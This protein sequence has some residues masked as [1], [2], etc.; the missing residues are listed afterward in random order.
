MSSK[1]LTEIFSVLEQRAKALGVEV[2]LLVERA[3]VFSLSVQKSEIEKFESSSSHCAGLR[4]LMD[5]YPG[6]AWTEDLSSEALDSAFDQ[7]IENAR[8]TAQANDASLKVEL[9][10]V[11]QAGTGGHEL[12]LF[13]DGLSKVSI[14][15]KLERARTLEKAARD[16]D[17]RV[18]AVPYNGYTES[19]SEVLLWSSRG[20]HRSQRR[21]SISGNS[22]CLV[23]NDDETRMGGESFFT[24]DAQKTP[25]REIA[26]KAAVKALAKLGAKPPKTGRYPI[27][28]ESRVAASVMGLVSSGFSAKEVFEKN[29][30]F[31]QELGALIASPVL[32]MVDDPHLEGGLGS[33][34]FDGEGAWTKKTPIVTAGKLEHFITDSVHARR[35]N[36]PHT[37]SAAR[38]AR[39]ELGVGFSNLVVLPG[40]ASLEELL[41]RY[42]SMILITEFKGYHAGYQGRSGDFSFESE[43]ELWEN[44]KRVGA[45]CNFVTSG[46]VRELLRNLQEVGADYAPR[47]SSVLCPDLLVGE[48]AVAGV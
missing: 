27:V 24:R 3:D 28:L 11:D 15:E 33:R 9:L 36:L 4:V 34:S 1:T 6:H 17:P 19:E 32:S 40:S 44:G 21:T 37:A 14:D 26:E 29:S 39:S 31:A 16:F 30:L 7:A 18:S 22:Y 25:V 10:A 2:E 20:I 45:L 8:F 43:G 35:M 13:S 41:S 46:N 47:V 48:L 5:G 23:K 12:A 38:G 42:P